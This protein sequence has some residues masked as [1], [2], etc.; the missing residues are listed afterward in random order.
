MLRELQDQISSEASVPSD[1]NDGGHRG[2]D[3]GERMRSLGR[4]SIQRE[5]TSLRQK[6]DSRKKLDEL[7]PSVEKAREDVV[8]CLRDKD[9]RPLDCWKE[10]DV[11]RQQVGRLEKGFVERTLR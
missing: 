5:I 11:F 3:A 6:L 8:Q 2:Q 4:E 9:R 1:G 10:V 7:D